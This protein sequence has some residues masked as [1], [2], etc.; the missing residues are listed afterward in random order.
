MSKQNLAVRLRDLG[1]YSTSMQL[2]EEVLEAMERTL[3]PGHID[4]LTCKNNLARALASLGDFLAAREMHAQALEAGERVFGPDHPFTLTSK[5]NLAATLMTLGDYAA[6]REMNAQVLEAFVRL[7]GPDHPDTLTAMSNLALS[8][9]ELGD[10]AAARHMLAQVL[11]AKIRILGPDHPDTLVTQNNL[12]MDLRLL[13]EYTEARVLQ[14]DALAAS[15]RVSGHDGEQ[16][17]IAAANMGAIF[18]E[19]GDL[20]KAVFFMKLSVDAAQRARVRISELRRELRRTY[21][22]TVQPRYRALFGLLIRQG[23]LA[24]ALGVLGL[25][26]EEELSGLAAA[27]GPGH[28]Q[29]EGQGEGAP[30]RA[31]GSSAADA[32][33]EAEESGDP[34]DLFSG[35]RDEADWKAYMSA[36]SLYRSLESERAALEEKRGGGTLSDTE[37]GRLE[38]LPVLIEDARAELLG[39]CERGGAVTV[40]P[41]GLDPG[42]WAAKRLADRQALLSE[43]GAGAALLHAVSEDDSLWLVMVTA[44]KVTAEETKVGRKRLAALASEFRGL[45]AS[46]GRDPREA[47]AKLYDA[48][49]RPVEGELKSSGTRTL[50][51]SLDGELRYAPMAALWDGE[52]WLAEKYP[53][54]LFTEST[55]A[56]LGDAPY[57]GAAS[58]R[59]L[60]V[61]AAWPGFPALPGVAAELAAVVRTPESPDGAIAGEARLDA[62]FDR[63]AL[64]ESLASD[65]PVVHVAS[66]FRLD[67]M[68]L[69]NTVLLLGDGARL[70][71]REI[72][73]RGDLDFRGLDLLTLSA[74]DTASGT[75]GGEGREVESLGEVVQRAG[76]SA[77]LATLLPVV[78]RAAPG[79]MREFYRLRY[80][81]G[82]DKAT[83]LQGAQ[84]IAI[85][86]AAPVASAPVAATAGGPSVGGGPQSPAGADL[87]DPSSTGTRG[88]AI[89]STGISG[90]ARLSSAPPWEGQGFSHPYY[91]APFV[92]MGSWR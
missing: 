90:G 89:G 18:A 56:R 24:E 9:R 51:L 10:H 30:G 3:G 79:F 4:T 85:R 45:V 72:S 70:S 86:S 27:S 11:K 42:S 1:D 71:L 31:A 92:L 76:A 81:R 60:G 41:V 87:A 26:K 16:T 68:S 39:I 32:D 83:A 5:N 20:G 64:G 74:C 28:G 61:T 35:T 91:W 7:K 77:V 55:A 54:T 8:S 25:L 73:L 59:A 63:A 84:L 62:A 34:A 21:L 52:R 15:A 48:L 36:M 38:G 67:P 57:S 12:A 23:R 44:D 6:A 22:S 33:A 66:H 47:G 78:D 80:A 69:E 65:A 82:L 50:M 53:V 2:H 43:M 29:A 49:I 58:V 14:V 37:S 19:T 17:A 13:G 46:P 88:T 75:R 40:A